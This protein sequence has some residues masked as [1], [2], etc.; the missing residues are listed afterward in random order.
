M[1]SIKTVMTN[2][3]RRCDEL[4]AQAEQDVASLKWET[5][6]LSVGNFIQGLKS[7]LKHEENILFPDFEET[8]GMTQGPTMMMRQ[9]HDQ[10]R[11][12]LV[13]MEKAI[14]NKNQDRYIG[15]SDTL[16]LFMQQHNMKEEQILYPMIDQDCAA[17]ADALTLAIRNI[18]K[19]D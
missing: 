8:T 1:I 4:F 13:E 9:E 6:Q 3:H 2:D 11:E 18:N 5:A 14:T 10:M 15:L 12:I 17:R 19:D 16:L 7:H